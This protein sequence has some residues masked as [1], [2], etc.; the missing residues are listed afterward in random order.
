MTFS[1]L[2]LL[3]VLTAHVLSKGCLASA[4]RLR[5]SAHSQSSAAVDSAERFTASFQKDTV[6]ETARAIFLEESD[7]EVVPLEAWPQYV[8]NSQVTKTIRRRRRR[9]MASSINVED[10]FLA[11]PLKYWIVLIVFAIITL[12][13]SLNVFACCGCC[14]GGEQAASDDEDNKKKTSKSGGST[15]AP[16]DTTQ[17]KGETGLATIHEKPATST[18]EKKSSWVSPFATSRNADESEN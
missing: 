11:I 16:T 10:K 6:E 14:S 3:G 12:C 4:P 1:R 2:I 17:P 5:S 13:C 18:K 7:G 15:V 9:L 8:R